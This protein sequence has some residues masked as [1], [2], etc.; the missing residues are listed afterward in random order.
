MSKVIPDLTLKD[1]TYHIDVS[2]EYNGVHLHDL[3]DNA[4]IYLSENHFRK[5]AKALGYTKQD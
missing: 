1:S 3:G 2:V 4:E 5:L